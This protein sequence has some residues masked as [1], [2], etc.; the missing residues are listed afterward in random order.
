MKKAKSLHKWVYNNIK[1]SLSS[2]FGGSTIL[3]KR[4][5]NCAGYCNL[6]TSLARTVGIPTS[7]LYM[8]PKDYSGTHV[9]LLVYIKTGSSWKIYKFEH[10]VFKFNYN[11]CNPSKLYEADNIYGCELAF[12]HWYADKEASFNFI[13]YFSLYDYNN[14]TYKKCL[15]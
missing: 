13:R 7:Y 6:F 15:S 8:S 1:Y 9:L 5:G 3:K 11:Q 12:P 10:Q 14:P 2:D 4:K